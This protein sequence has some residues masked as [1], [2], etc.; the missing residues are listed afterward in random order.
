MG[1]RKKNGSSGPASGP[2]TPSVTPAATPR[3]RPALRRAAWVAA[4]AV[5]AVGAI[6]A[7]RA[8]PPRTDDQARSRVAARRPA[9][10]SVNVVVVTLDTLRADRLGCYGFRNIETP[11][12][13]ALA[14]E[15]VLFEQ[16]TATAPMTLPSHASIFT[17]LIP[18][19]HGVRDNG[20]F[21]LRRMRII[22]F[23][24]CNDFEDNNQ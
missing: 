11:N 5:L 21:F 6:F 17:G 23:L 3:G 15:G 8:L 1:R 12:M 16:A 22:F 13:D 24:N 4:L 14:A 7:L 19:N 9:P 2:A 10:S 20:G 18:P